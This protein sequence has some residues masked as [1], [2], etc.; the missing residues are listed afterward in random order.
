[1]LSSVFQVALVKL[2]VKYKIINELKQIN[3]ALISD[4]WKLN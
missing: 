3:P 1:M 2:W 4:E